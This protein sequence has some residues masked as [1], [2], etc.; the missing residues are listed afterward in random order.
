[1][2]SISIPVLGLESLLE[3]LAPPV[4]DGNT[5]TRLRVCISDL[6]WNQVWHNMRWDT[7]SISPA[8]RHGTTDV[9]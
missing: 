3:S 2:L 8:D 5:P 9:S 6:E 4:R 7:R 1:M